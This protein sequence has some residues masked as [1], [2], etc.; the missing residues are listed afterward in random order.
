MLCGH[1]TTNTVE[2]EFFFSHQPRVIMGFISVMWTITL[3]RT[4][5]IVLIT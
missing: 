2:R 3:V 5:V 1:I 4:E